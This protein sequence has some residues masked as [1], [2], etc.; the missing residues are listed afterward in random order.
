METVTEENKGFGLSSNRHQFEWLQETEQA[1]SN[2]QVLLGDVYKVTKSY[3]KEREAIR[4]MKM[5]IYDDFERT[6]ENRQLLIT[7]GET[8]WKQDVERDEGGV[9]SRI[10]D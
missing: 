1:F 9:F 10:S 2:R 3:I 7:R 6:L 8:G 4:N 5:A